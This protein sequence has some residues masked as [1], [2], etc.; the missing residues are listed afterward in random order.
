MRAQR[1][2][3]LFYDNRRPPKSTV[4]L[5]LFPYTTLFRSLVR[6]TDEFNEGLIDVMLTAPI[7]K[8][9]I[10]SEE[11][12][13]PGHT[14]YLETKCGDGEKSLMILM[15]DT[16]RVALVTT[17]VP[18]SK[19]PSLITPDNIM[20]KLESFNKT[21]QQDFDIQK[22]RIAVLSL[23]PHNGEEGL[24]G[25]EEIEVIKP[26]IEQAM[27]NGILCFG[28]YA[29]DGFFGSLK[30]QEFDGVLAMYHDQGLAPFKTIAMEEGV[31]FTAGIPL[32]RTSPDHGTAYD[33]AGKG[34]ASEESFR[35]AL[36][37]ALDTFR[38]RIN[39]K[40]MRKNP[41]RK[42]Y[43]DKSGDNEKLDLTTEAQND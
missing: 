18:L 27:M 20:E 15:Q 22:P 6:A 25:M 14:E 28:P 1:S 23:N 17:H 38:N 3:F 35:Q 12:K 10:Q 42:Q 32:I 21:L 30:Y 37:V 39:Y 34:I 7:N 29:S 13:F 8:H 36:Y 40:E 16:L 41:L 19:V 26:T 11:F 2:L 43:F 4:I 33:I 9:N 24:L 5:T 31:N